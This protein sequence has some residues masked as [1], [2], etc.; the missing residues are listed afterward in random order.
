MM[1]VYS[2]IRILR[3]QSNIIVI[4]TCDMAGVRSGKTVTTTDASTGA[5]T[6]TQYKYTTLSGKLTRLEYNDREIDF[7]YDEDGRPYAMV[8]ESSTN[9][10]A[11]KQIFN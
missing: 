7:I 9:D 11:Q 1:C 8:Y 6:T 4:C 5:T 10:N 2:I 3:F